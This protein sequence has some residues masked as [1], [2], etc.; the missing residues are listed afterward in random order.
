MSFPTKPPPVFP[1][2][3]NSLV[4]YHPSPVLGELKGALKIADPLTDLGKLHRLI[5][6]RLAQFFGRGFLAV[7][8]NGERRLS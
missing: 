8:E 3:V 2:T 6:Q 4:L 7:V 5:V 1:E